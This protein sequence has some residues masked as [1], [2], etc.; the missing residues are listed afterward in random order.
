MKIRFLVA[1]S[2][3]FGGSFI[4]INSLTAH[5]PDGTNYTNGWQERRINLFLSNQTGHPNYFR[6]SPDLANGAVAAMVTWNNAPANFHYNNAGA[7]DN[8]S[9]NCNDYSIADN[10]VVWGTI[11]GQGGR[12]GQ[13]SIC[14][15]GPG[16]IRST[17]LQ[18]DGQEN[19]WQ[20][21]SGVPPAGSLEFRSVI[22][23]E[24]G[25]VNG[26][27]SNNFA[28]WEQVS[29]SLCPFDDRRQT[30][31]SSIPAGTS[32]M[33]TLGSHDSHTFTNRYPA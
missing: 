7:A 31:C 28:H 5:T 11:D 22:T 20:I 17:F 1:I 9:N 32:Y 4:P 24:M 29:G 18:I 8:L 16:R 13:T 27:F 25:H 10:V 6:S 33:R 21:G 2:I 15:V 19:N 30:M 14:L 3:A 23:H 12:L 26:L